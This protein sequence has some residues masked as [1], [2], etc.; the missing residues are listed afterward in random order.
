[1]NE[2]TNE[3]MICLTSLWPVIHCLL[4]SLRS[5]NGEKMQGPAGD[6]RLLLFPFSMDVL[7]LYTV[8]DGLALLRCSSLEMLNFR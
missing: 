3:Q 8:G 5:S 4:P 1:M 7:P 2:E 6:P